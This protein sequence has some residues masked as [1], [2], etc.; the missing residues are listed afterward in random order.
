MI[1]SAMSAALL[2]AHRSDLRRY[3][4]LLAT[5][6]GDEERNHLHRCIA[7]TRLALDRL[8]Q[9]GA[10]G[11]AAARPSAPGPAMYAA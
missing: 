10:R 4:Q 1:M 5:E 2:E 11:Q 6:L 8:E 7:E 3:C 9:G